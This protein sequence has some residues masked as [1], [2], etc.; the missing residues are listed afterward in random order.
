M[1]TAVV[2]GLNI[3]YELHGE[4]D[5]IALTC[6]GRFSKD[7]HGYR[8]LAQ[9]LAE[10]GKQ[11]LIWDRPNC[12]ASD[13]CFE[14][15]SEPKLHADTLAGLIRELGLGRTVIAGGSAGSRVSLLTCVRHPEIVSKLAVWWISG[16]NYGLVMLAAHYCGSNFEAVKRGGMQ[17]VAELPEWQETL[18]KSPSNRERLL[19]LDPERFAAT[20]EAWMPG[21]LP[22]SGSPV[23]G[24]EPEELASID[25]PSLIL[26]SGASDIHHPRG[27]SEWVHELIPGARLVEPPWGDTE[28][29]TRSDDYQ[30]TGENRLFASWP[31]LAPQLLAFVDEPVPHA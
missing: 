27:T 14:A 25:V 15:E 31:E 5:P 3:A 22:T 19:A 16:G 6:G 21:F 17:A 30:R 2:N 8:E 28:W 23:P 18:T 13:V 7:V 10:G 20:M 12:G 4:G 9:T 24:I 11:V 26:R 29:M 1:P